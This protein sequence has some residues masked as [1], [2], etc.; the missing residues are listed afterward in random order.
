MGSSILR[1][2]MAY[3]P[4]VGDRLPW[5]CISLRCSTAL[6]IRP[7]GR[8]L[9]FKITHN[10]RFQASKDLLKEDETAMEDNWKGV[11]ES[12]TL[13]CQEILGRN[14]HH[15]KEWISMETLDKIQEIKN[16]KTAINNSRT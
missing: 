9:G 4:I 14:K 8:R 16:K 6:W 15:Y 5:D 11:K 1:E 7:T 2:Q 10:N 13:T 3:E 12:L